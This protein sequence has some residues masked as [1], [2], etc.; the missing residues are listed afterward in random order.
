MIAWQSTRY[1]VEVSIPRISPVKDGSHSENIVLM[2][3]DLAGELPGRDIK[4][5]FIPEVILR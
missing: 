2:K 4:N 5:S 3:E 1:T